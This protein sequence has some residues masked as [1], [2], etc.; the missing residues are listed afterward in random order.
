MTINQFIQ[1]KINSENNI[2]RTLST[3]SGSTLHIFSSS[4]TSIFE[5]VNR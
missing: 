2:V 4:F 1:G 5:L 3:G